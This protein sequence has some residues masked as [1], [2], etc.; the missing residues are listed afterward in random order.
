MNKIAKVLLYYIIFKVVCTLFLLIYIF[1]IRHI[2]KSIFTRDFRNIINNLNIDSNKK[3]D[4]NYILNYRGTSIEPE[5]EWVKNISFVYTWV[6]GS[7]PNFS[8]LKSKYNGGDRDV[9]SRDR[10]ADELRYSLRSLKKYLPWHNGTIFIVTNNQIPKWLKVNNNCI[11]IVNHEDI[12]PKYINPTFDSSTIEC[13]LDKIPG[14]GEIFI[15][16]ND[17]FFF[18]N[19]VQ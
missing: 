5:W 19:Y 10:S 4:L 6:D 13:F 9:N 7:D 2:Q 12:I 1:R 17:D 3:K 14:I 16:L 15:Y 18:N 8:Y 11:K